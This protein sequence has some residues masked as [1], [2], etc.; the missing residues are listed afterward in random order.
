M[1][2]KTAGSLQ[3]G[4]D[5]LQQSQQRTTSISNLGRNQTKVSVK[6]CSGMK[7]QSKDAGQSQAGIEEKKL[8]LHDQQLPPRPRTRRRSATRAS[9]KSPH[10][11]K[12]EQTP[13]K[14]R[15]RYNKAISVHRPSHGTVRGRYRSYS[16]QPASSQPSSTRNGSVDESTS[17]RGIRF[18]FSAIT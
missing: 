9:V 8:S 2:V 11:K 16:S 13:L 17:N 18:F 4:N 5:I 1:Q 14:T 3:A 10:P 12:K 7:R 6:S 15:V